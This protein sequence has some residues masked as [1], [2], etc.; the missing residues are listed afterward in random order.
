MADH[1]V[2]PEVRVGF[3]GGGMMAEAIIRGILHK[4]VVEAQSIFVCEFLPQRRQLLSEL[5]INTTDDAKEMLKSSNVVVLAIKPNDVP[6]V[7][8][9]INDNQSAKEDDTLY[10]SICAGITLTAL[11]EAQPAHGETKKWARVMPNQP[12]VVGAAASAFTMNHKCDECDK[13]VVEGLMGACG[14][15]VQVPEKNLDAVTGLSGSGPAFV[16]MMIEAM[17][18]AGVR[19][20]LPRSTAYKL[21]SQTVFGSA[22]MALEFDRHPAELRNRVESPGGTTIAGTVAL[23]S[24]G[25]RAAVIDAISKAVDRSAELG[26]K[27]AT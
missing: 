21:A 16:F 4:E 11:S 5:N 1:S 15:V 24:G 7:L 19:K 8:R 25:F 14:M 23:E 18:D 12:C 13:T 27:N 17:T 22:K 6:N 3:F 26:R 10:I 2:I 9:T 20:G